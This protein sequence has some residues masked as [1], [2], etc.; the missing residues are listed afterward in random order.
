MPTPCRLL[1]GEEFR[2][3]EEGRVAAV[4]AWRDA[5]PDVHTATAWP[6]ELVA[7]SRSFRP[8]G[9]M[10]FMPWYFDPKEDGAAEKAA[11]WLAHA[12]ADPNAHHYLSVHYLTDWADKRPPLNVVCPDYSDWTVDA[13]SSNGSGWT[14]TGEAPLISCSPSIQVP[15]YHGYLTNGVFTDG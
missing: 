6:P 15:G 3:S 9:T 13:K 4:T 5:H 1:T 14:V 10:W 2:A 11:K 7:L 12:R 8:P